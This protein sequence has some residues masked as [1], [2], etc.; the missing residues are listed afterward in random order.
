MER[1]PHLNPICSQHRRYSNAD[2]NCPK[3]HPAGPAEEVREA[4]LGILENPARQRHL[5]HPVGNSFLS[6]AWENSRPSRMSWGTK[7]GSAPALDRTSRFAAE[8][9]RLPAKLEHVCFT[10][11]MLLIP[12]SVM[13]PDSTPTINLVAVLMKHNA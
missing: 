7:A 13:G 3:P 1:F 2:R 6:A 5:L 11:L 4:V 12:L 8:A 9:G 10:S